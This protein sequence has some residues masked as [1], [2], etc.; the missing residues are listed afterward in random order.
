MLLLKNIQFSDA[1]MHGTETVQ[2][3]PLRR[4][5][6][7]SPLFECYDCR[8]KGHAGSKTLLQHDLVV[9][10]LGAS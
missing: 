4:T 6:A 1:V 5:V 10:S 2:V 8:Q 9:F 3:S 7:S